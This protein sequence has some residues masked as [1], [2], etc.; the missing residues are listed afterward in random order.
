[1]SRTSVVGALGALLVVSSVVRL[2]MRGRL[3]VQYAALWLV[4]GVAV[5]GIAVVPGVLDATATSLGFTVPANFLFFAGLVLLLLVGIHLSVALT[6]AEDH[7]Q[8]LA[9]EVALLRERMGRPDRH[10]G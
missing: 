10:S 8:R 7:V 6:R 5:A 1:M 3:R 2:I 9:E 4:I